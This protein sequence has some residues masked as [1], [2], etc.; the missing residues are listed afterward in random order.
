MRKQLADIKD[1]KLSFSIFPVEIFNLMVSDVAED[2]LDYITGST[3]P[4]TL[5]FSEAISVLKK[6]S[7][8]D[9]PAL[10]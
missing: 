9:K 3:V 5:T 7:L 2:P 4:D 10:I 6:Y 8:W 1:G